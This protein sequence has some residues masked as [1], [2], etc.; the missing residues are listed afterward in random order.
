[1]G[2]GLP[3]DQLVVESIAWPIWYRAFGVFPEWISDVQRTRVNMGKSHVNGKRKRVRECL[4]L[5]ADKPVARLEP[6]TVGLDD[7]GGIRLY[8]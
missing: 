5:Q 2:E 8:G 4:C 1:M 6:D 7:L 3:S